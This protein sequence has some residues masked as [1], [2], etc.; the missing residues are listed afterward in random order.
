M[1]GGGHDTG[2]HKSIPDVFH[3]VLNGIRSRSENN[4]T[5]TY[6][7]KHAHTEHIVILNGRKRRRAL[8]QQGRRVSHHHGNLNDS[9]GVRLQK[10][11]SHTQEAQ[12]TTNKE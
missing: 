10:T 12:G 8:I 4:I 2:E 7:H 3:R 9:R 11:D 6:T 5:H 1:K